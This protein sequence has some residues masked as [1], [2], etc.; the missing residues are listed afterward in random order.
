M[1]VK[2]P[3]QAPRPLQLA[4]H[5]QLRRLGYYVAVL[6]RPGDV[7]RILDEIEGVDKL[8]DEI[9]EWTESIDGVD[10]LLDEKGGDTK[11]G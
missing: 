3:G 7:S 1:E 9:E 8:L 10:K 2:A 6:D 5:R 4:R 11:N